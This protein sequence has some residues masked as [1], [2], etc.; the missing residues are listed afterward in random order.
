MHQCSYYDYNSCTY[1]YRVERAVHHHLPRE[2][3]DDI[4]RKIDLLIPD[5]LEV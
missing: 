4:V 1:L 3:H 5:L 2:K